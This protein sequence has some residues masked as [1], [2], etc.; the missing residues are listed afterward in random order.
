GNYGG[1]KATA[2]GQNSK[3]TLQCLEAEY[4][5]NLTLDQATVLALKAIAKSLDS[6][7]VTAEKLELCTISRDASRKKGNQIIF[8]T[9]TKQEIADMIEEHREELIR[10]DEEEQED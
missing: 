2:I 4:N 10:R 1:W 9:L 7:N 5:E 3:Q 6:A 8:K